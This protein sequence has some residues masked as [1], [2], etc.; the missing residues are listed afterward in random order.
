MLKYFITVCL[1]ILPNVSYGFSS[2]ADLVE[3]LMP[4]VVN[5]STVKETIDENEN[6]DNMM[7]N[8]S[9]D[10]REALGSGFF[11]RGDG[12]ILTNNHV[13][14][15]AKKI[16]II[17]N[18]N[19]EY[20]ASIIGS[21]KISDLAVLKI[22]PKDKEKT[23]KTVSF[24]NAENARIGDIVLTFGNPY[25]LGVSVSQGII[26][27]KSRNIGINNLQY[28]QTDASINQGNSGG[29]MFNIDGEVIGINTALFT[30][31]G[32]SGVG[33][34]LPSNT[35]NWIAS[36]LIEKGKVKRGWIGMKVSNGID[37]YT[38]KSGFVV[39]EINEES[40]AYKEGLRVGDI[41]IAYN[42]KIAS[43]IDEFNLFTETMDI[44]QALRLKII[45]YGEEM[46][47]IVRIQEMPAEELKVATSNA[48]KEAALQS[49]EKE[50]SDAYYVSEL[51]VT[52]KEADP[53]GLMIVKLD[54]QSA[55]KG[56]GINKGDIILEAD[57]S[58]IYSVDNLLENIRYAMI[59]DYRPISL[60]IQNEE[61]AFYVTVELA[62]END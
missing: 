36:Q 40:N 24:G 52:V 8:P 45:S 22:T 11:I 48:L 62:A 19:E 41:I 13:I 12:Y 26:S 53:R 3:T 60:L 5:I 59:D 2:Y 47:V 49:L 35:A 39:T 46:K 27:A 25:G 21:D 57:R 56:K 29:P 28:L 10:G 9:L 1:L 32:A 7:L 43:D 55:L 17:T 20:E 42:D 33:F 31:Q 15:G 4:S 18:D 51:G 30:I 58:D 44:G 6:I 50:D 34:S 61:N 54:R 38:D 16:T 37:K 14:N 23:F